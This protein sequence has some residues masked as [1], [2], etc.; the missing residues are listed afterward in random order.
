MTLL[1]RY[2]TYDVF[3]AEDDYEIE[4]LYYLDD[5]DGPQMLKNFKKQ[6]LPLMSDKAQEIEEWQEETKTRR[7]KTT[8]DVYRCV[9]FYNELEWYSSK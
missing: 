9:S 5:N 1:R 8:Q 6:I 7:F 3:D 4:E 2:L